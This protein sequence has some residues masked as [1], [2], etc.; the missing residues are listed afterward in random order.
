MP[1]EKAQ[2]VLAGG[3]CWTPD[4]PYPGG[5]AIADGRLVEVGDNG[6]LDGWVGP[7]TRV[8]DLDGGALLPGINDGH[9]HLTA[10][11][12]ARPAHAVDVGP[13]HVRSLAELADVVGKAAAGRGPDDWVMGGGWDATEIAECAGT[14]R[15]PGRDDI[16]A[17]AAGRPVI[18][19]DVT[20]HQALA[21]TRALDLAG[22]SAETNDPEGGHLVRDEA[23]RLTGVLQESAQALLRDAR[24]A[25]TREALAAAQRTAIAELQRLGITSVTE[26]GLGPGG[27][28]LFDGAAGP[29]AL[30][31]LHD[32]E[33]QGELGLRVAVLELFGGLSGATA[34]DLREGLR[35]R[36]PRAGSARLR[37]TGCKVFADGIPR[38]RTAWMA[39]PYAGGGHG[40]L[41]VHGEDDDARVAELAE[42]VATVAGA[43]Q[44]LGIHVLGDRAIDAV[45]DGLERVH[46]APTPR[47]PHHLVHADYVTERALVRLARLNVGIS[48]QPQV[49]W[50]ANGLVREL[51]GPARAARQQPLRSAIDAGVPTAISSDAPVTSPD[52]RRAAHTA[53]TRT[54]REGPGTDDDP[55]RITLVEAIRACTQIGA[56]QDGQAA[57]KGALTA[58][59]LADCCVLDGP[60]DRPDDLLERE[61]VATVLDG[62]LVHEAWS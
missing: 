11:G 35:D 22:I 5:V 20:G 2:V 15:L 45:I 34:A 10:Y 7:G 3:Q 32:L 4:G 33:E 31:A 60:L 41:G 38:N 39:E 8:I 58:G 57:D 25:P 40:C 62:E 23:G 28:G 53:I 61:V 26:P 59:R 1:V 56:W 46:D 27:T 14:G 50:M 55:E 42:I 13:E 49:R 6:R 37:V 51:L 17:A 9:L 16:D 19:T 12:R 44:Q 47:A 18:L 48:F 52:W 21:S 36:G 24:P 29:E 43:G 54:T 30:E